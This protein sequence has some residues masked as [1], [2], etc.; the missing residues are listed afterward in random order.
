MGRVR[1]LVHSFFLHTVIA[2]SWAEVKAQMFRVHMIL[3]QHRHE[4]ISLMADKASC[5]Q[6]PKGLELELEAWV[7]LFLGQLLPYLNC[8]SILKDLPFLLQHNPQAPRTGSWYFFNAK[9]M[10]ALLWISP[11]NSFLLK[12]KNSPMYCRVACNRQSIQTAL[13]GTVKHSKMHTEK[14]QMQHHAYET[15]PSLL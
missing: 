6:M 1:S 8:S 14:F 4:C 13:L 2:S 15:Q 12:K 5:S 11:L 9:I 10:N 7:A 3:L